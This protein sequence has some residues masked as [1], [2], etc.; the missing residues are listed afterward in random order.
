MTA[1]RR[2]GRAL[3]PLALVASLGAVDGVAP[4]GHVESAA[5]A[6]GGAC[7]VPQRSHEVS[8][9]SGAGVHVELPSGVVSAALPHLV[10]VRVQAGDSGVDE[11]VTLIGPPVVGALEICYSG[12]LLTEYPDSNAGGRQQWN[13]G[14]VDLDA[15]Q[16]VVFNAFYTLGPAPGE[17]SLPDQPQDF[18]FDARAGSLD[19]PT[20]NLSA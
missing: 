3:I 1:R 20:A 12:I 5:A 14:H 19:S 13:L 18:A 4:L 2:L 16:A 11:D 8:D 6:E 7:N 17:S 15:G 10:K 9:G